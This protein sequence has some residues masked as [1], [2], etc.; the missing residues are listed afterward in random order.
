MLNKE[1]LKH[2][3][4]VIFISHEVEGLKINNNLDK[5]KNYNIVL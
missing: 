3:T 1:K 2:I 4:R 5:T